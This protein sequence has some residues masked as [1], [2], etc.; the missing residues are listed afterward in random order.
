[1]SPSR[2]PAFAAP[3]PS[4]TLPTKKP[5]LTGMVYSSAKRSLNSGLIAFPLTPNN[6]FGLTQIPPSLQILFVQYYWEPQT[7]SLQTPESEVMAVLIPINSPCVLTNAPPLFPRL[8]A[9][10][11]CKKIDFYHRLR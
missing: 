7:N 8:T 2:I 3:I 4:I 10:S 5:S 11:V 6:L 1:M 9:A